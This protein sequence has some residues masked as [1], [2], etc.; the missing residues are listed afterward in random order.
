M[1]AFLVD[2]LARTFK[3]G[4]ERREAARDAPA[5]EQG[6]LQHPR[7]SA[8]VETAHAERRERMLEERQKLHRV[9][10]A[11]D[12]LNQEAGEDA[13]R[14]KGQGGAGK[15]VDGEVP[16]AEFNGDAPGDRPVR[17]DHRDRATRA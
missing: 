2:L 12:R 13:R 11:G 5:A 7:G 10:I 9:A 16:A 17:R 6:D 8:A 15:I 1:A 3:R 4:S 14:R